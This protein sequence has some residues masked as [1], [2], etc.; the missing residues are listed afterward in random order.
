MQGDCRVAENLLDQV[1]ETY[2]DSHMWLAPFVN[3]YFD[4]VEQ[5]FEE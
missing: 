4:S 5:N 2:D 3:R 1:N